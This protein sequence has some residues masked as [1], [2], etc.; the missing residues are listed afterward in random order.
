[1]P[2]LSVAAAFLLGLCV[3][4]GRLFDDHEF[5]VLYDLPEKFFEQD[6][7]KGVRLENVQALRSFVAACLAKPDGEARASFISGTV[8]KTHAMENFQG[9][10]RNVYRN[11]FNASKFSSK[12]NG[13]VEAALVENEAHP[14]QILSDNPSLD[15]SEGTLPDIKCIYSTVERPISQAVFG[16]NAITSI[17]VHPGMT[18]SIS[19]I[20]H[21]NWERMRKERMR[22]K[23]LLEAAKNAVKVASR[24]EYCLI[25]S[26][27]AL[28]FFQRSRKAHHLLQIKL[29]IG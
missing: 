9:I 22:A 5:C 24:R 29:K 23:K 8:G 1:M 2:S 7:I 15:D 4:N 13:L 26:N 19:A 6:S 3:E 21:H 25:S 16:K 17:V 12:I 14:R 28:T 18:T 11:W 27:L 10:G 20:L